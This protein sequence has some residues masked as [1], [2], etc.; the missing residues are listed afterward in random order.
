MRCAVLGAGSW[1][2]ALAMQL[3]RCGHDTLLWD[4]DAFRARRHEAARENLRYLPGMRFPDGLRVLSQLSE[5]VAE[6][7][8]VVTVVP[9]TAMRE[10]M[11]EAGRHIPQRAIVCSASKG[12]EQKSLLTMD[13]VLREALAEPLHDRIC[14]LSGPSFAAEVARDLP[15]TVVVAGRDEIATHRVASAFHGSNFRVYHSGDIAGVEIGGAIKNVMAIACG[16][17]DG[18]NMG[19]NARAAIITRGLAEITRL[20]VARG[21]NPLTLAGLAGLGDLVLTCTGDLSRNR[22]VGLGLGQGRTLAEILEG[23]GQVAEGVVTAKSAYELGT[24]MDVEMPISEQVYLILY[25]DKPPRQALADL[26]GRRRKA[27]HE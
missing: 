19:Q 2:T 27:E 25:Q 24:R 12:V 17:A 11:A 13:E 20:A 7:E 4:H 18:M 3:S 14:V 8:L 15:T 6:A 16:I 1:G 5:A 22:R 9:S 23:L 21:A 10:V 26:L